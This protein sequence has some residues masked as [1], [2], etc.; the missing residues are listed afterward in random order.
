MLPLPM[1]EKGGSI[2][3]LR[4]FLNYGSEENWILILAFLLAAFRPD[5][6]FPILVFSGEQGS[7]KSTTA[8]VLRRMLDPSEAERRSHPR[9]LTISHTSK[10]PFPT[11][12]VSFRPA[13]R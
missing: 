5:G 6:P 12:S 3:E 4:P 10:P 2:E 8:S 7:A 13:E 11:P 9:I 1:P